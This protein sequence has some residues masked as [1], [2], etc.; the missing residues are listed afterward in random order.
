MWP[1]EVKISKTRK[2]TAVTT[3]LNG[4]SSVVVHVFDNKFRHISYLITAAVTR[5]T[6]VTCETQFIRGT[7]FGFI[8]LVRFSVGTLTVEIIALR[9]NVISRARTIKNRKNVVAR[10]VFRTISRN[11]E[12]QFC[13]IRCT[14]REISGSRFPSPT[15]QKYREN[16]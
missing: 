5:G 8:T 13:C 10:V 14:G 3:P 7:A 4:S 1:R 16:R 12:R 2:P 15:I 11:V 9:G 6:F